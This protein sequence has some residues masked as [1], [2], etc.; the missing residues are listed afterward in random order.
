VLISARGGLRLLCA[1]AGPDN[2]VFVLEAILGDPGTLGLALTAVTPELTMAPYGPML[3]SL[4]PLYEAS[5]ADFHNRPASWPPPS[6]PSTRPD[7]PGRSEPFLTWSGPALGHTP[8]SALFRLLRSSRSRASSMPER[9][10]TS[11]RLK[12]GP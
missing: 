12:T 7:G 11:A 4:L 5:M 1:Q 8:A 2:V 9:R 10:A 3:Q 6:P